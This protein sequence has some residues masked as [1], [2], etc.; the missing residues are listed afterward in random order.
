MYKHIHKHTHT[1]THIHTHTQVETLNLLS[2]SNRLLREEKDRL[3]RQIIEME[4]NCQKLEAEILPLKVHV[5]V[6]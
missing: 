2:D 1:H 4:E 6:N 3:V 5:H